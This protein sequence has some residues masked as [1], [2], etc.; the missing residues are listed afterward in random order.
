MSDER[1]GAGLLQLVIVGWSPKVVPLMRQGQRGGAALH[2]PCN[3]A[4]IPLSMRAN[5]VFCLDSDGETRILENVVTA[6]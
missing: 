3:N 5:P 2:A 6:S 1:G 4:C